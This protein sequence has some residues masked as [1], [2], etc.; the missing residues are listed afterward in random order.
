M[1]DNLNKAKVYALPA[2]ALFVAITALIMGIVAALQVNKVKSQTGSKPVINSIST[3]NGFQGEVNSNGEFILQTSIDGLLSSFQNQLVEAK[4]SDVTNAKLTGFQSQQGSISDKDSILVALQKLA[5]LKQTRLTGFTAQSGDIVETDSVMEALQKI[6]FAQTNSAIL[7]NLWSS[8]S[9]GSLTLPANFLQPQT[10]LQIRSYGLVDG[11][12]SPQ[13][14]T[15]Q[16]I[17]G[18][19]GSSTLSSTST[20]GAWLYV[21]DVS[22][23]VISAGL[24]SIRTTLR[25]FGPVLGGFGFSPLSYSDIQNMSFSPSAFQILNLKGSITPATS[26]LSCDFAFGTILFQAA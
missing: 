17:F 25:I 10:I 8:P 18:T 16:F 14:V 12:Q 22:L 7:V 26:T 4:P 15:L 9:Q 11:F 3:K 23:Q 13:V 19:N 24:A 6:V 20:N 2:I 1:E 5:V 21:H